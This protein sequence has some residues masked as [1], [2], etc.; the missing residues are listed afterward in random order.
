MKHETITT[1]I[2]TITPALAKVYLETNTHNR[3]T[4]EVRVQQYASAMRSGHW[5]LS[6]QGIA[7]DQDGVLKDGQHR[8]LAVIMAGKSVPMMVTKGLPPT[9]KVNG[10][11]VDI[12]DVFDNGAGRT[13]ADQLHLSHGFNNQNAMAAAC[14]TIAQICSGS[15]M[16]EKLTTPQALRVL[17]FYGVALEQY[18]RL[19]TAFKPGRLA[20][21]I[22]GLS[23]AHAVHPNLTNDFASQVVSG[24]GLRAN[25]PALAFRNWLTNGGHRKQF[26]GSNSSNKRLGLADVTLNMVHHFKGGEKV[27]TVRPGSFGREYFIKNQ[28]PA[29]ETIKALFITNQAAT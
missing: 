14:A 10:N 11:V 22:A 16:R 5:G 23:F 28:R 13:V 27:Q 24:V 8:L 7:I 3:K 15:G 2:E 25:D 1:E 21:V 20:S 4:R 12:M 6:H 26:V 19:L 29:V 18:H 17:E 9:F